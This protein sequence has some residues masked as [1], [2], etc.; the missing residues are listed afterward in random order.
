[1]KNSSPEI[2]DLVSNLL[3]ELID[4][5]TV[6]KLGTSIDQHMSFNYKKAIEA[7]FI[8]LKKEFNSIDYNEDSFLSIEEFYR[9]FASKNNNVKKE[10]I[11]CLFEL[12]DKDKNKKISLNEF[13]YIYILLEEKLKM[14]KE[15]LKDAKDSLS[16]KLK[17]YQ[18]KLKDYQNEEYNSNGISNDN[19]IKIHI[20]EITNL[21]SLIMSPKCKVLINL[22]DKKGDI[23]NEKETQLISGTSNPKFNEIFS[24]Q[25][26]DYNCYIKCILSDSDN[27]INDGYGSFVIKLIDLQDQSVHEMWYDVVGGSSG[28]RAHVSVS[29][30]YNNNK[31][32]KDLI[33]KTSQQIDKVSQNIFQI[34]NLIEKIN[35]PFGLI[36]FNK[37]KEI[38]DKKI[39]N[40]SEND[41]D[42]L[43]SSRISLYTD[44][45]N[46]K[47]SYSESPNNLNLID[48]REEDITRGKIGVSELGIIPEEGDGNLINSNLLRSVKDEVTSTE[49]FLPSLGNFKEYFPKKSSI[50]GKKSNQLIL[51][52]VIISILNIIFGKFDIVNLILYL[53]G[54]LI[55][56]NTYGI[57]AKFNNKKILF[58]CLLAGILIDIIWILFL[59]KEQEDQNSLFRAIVFGFT[60]FLMIIKITLCYLIKKRRR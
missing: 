31:K 37:I 9:F 45:R 22:M 36:M 23:I 46:S 42:Y 33:S 38:L 24:F 43:G 5:R 30:T 53:F 29:F 20:I 56:F 55:I 52:G 17:I 3:K 41:S 54:C 2:S 15:S 47:F 18:N 1:M 40:K 26:Q 34:E 58:Y 19:E 35:Q 59:N 44:P 16:S 6:K 7:K 14:K 51:I 25:V 13:I 10:E 49:G 39:L 32:Y 28:C 27:L 48:N 60:I 21:K 50:L 11:Q 8:Q 12:A 4:K 57:N